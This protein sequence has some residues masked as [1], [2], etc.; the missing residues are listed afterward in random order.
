MSPGV[1]YDN[2][3]VPHTLQFCE[4]V[5]TDAWDPGSLPGLRRCGEY[6]RDLNDYPYNDEPSGGS[7]R[8]ISKSE[9]ALAYLRID[10]YPGSGAIEYLWWRGAAQTVFFRFRMPVPACAGNCGWSWWYWW[11]YSFVGHFRGEIVTEE[12]YGVDIAT[13]WGDAR[14]TFSVADSRESTLFGRIKKEFIDPLRGEIG[15]LRLKLSKLD[16]LLMGAYS[17]IEQ[18]A[19]ERKK[20]ITGIW[21]KLEGWLIDRIVGILLAALDKEEE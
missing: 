11:A 21:D 10:N 20:D 14:I 7:S 13:S 1:E 18:E 15:D 19:Q 9:M 16:E 12:V 17:K 5:P 2:I 6:A 4:P 8:R 3:R